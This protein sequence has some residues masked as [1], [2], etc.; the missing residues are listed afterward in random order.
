MAPREQS[1]RNKPEIAIQA[2]DTGVE[3]FD[4]YRD[5]NC[6]GLAVK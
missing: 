4:T 5:E 2:L 6:R 3:M 1:M